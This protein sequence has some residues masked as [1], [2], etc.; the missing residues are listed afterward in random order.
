MNKP[1]NTYTL[2]IE[3]ARTGIAMSKIDIQYHLCWCTQK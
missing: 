1:E 2:D 3:L